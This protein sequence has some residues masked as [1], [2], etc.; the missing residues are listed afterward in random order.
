M[1][2]Q[3]Q[4]LISVIVP[5]YNVEHYLNKCIKSL[6]SQTYSNLEIIFINDGS[7]DQS[8]VILEQWKKRDSRIKLVNQVN[9][10]LSSARNTGIR[11][12][13]GEY[14]T[15]VDSDDYV[16][17]DYVEYMF[18]LLKKHNFK[19]P[20]AICSLMDV[21]SDSNKCQNMGNGNTI[22]LSGKDCIKK[23]CYHDLVDTCAYA[24][25]GKRELYN[26]HFFPEEMLFEDIGST[27]KL[28]L[29]SNTVECGFEPKYFYVI[30]RNSIVTSSFNSKKL[31]LLTMTDKMAAD[32]K[33]Q[34]PDL[35]NAVLR[36][37]VYARFS[38]LNQTLNENKNNNNIKK[39][40]IKL[41]SYINKYKNSIL[42][43]PN[44][45]R[46]D[47]AAYIMLSLGL[48]FYKISWNIY[49]KIKK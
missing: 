44:I 11:N 42:K 5:V 26:D 40:Q 34:F 31:D 35:K 30:K 29:Q 17:N 7:T 6:V 25:L 33:N 43:D 8:L 46:R 24:K 3:N 23:M 15:F 20:L 16:T 47:R 19:S 39:I 49:L 4:P 36:R 37:Q 10:G 9:Q 28:F 2:K 48:Q 41:I 12:S 13:S 32:V 45:P 1:K 22:T 21:Y 18:N 38:T 27:Y 14:L